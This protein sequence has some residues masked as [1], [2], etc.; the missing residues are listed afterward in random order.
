MIRQSEAGMLLCLCSKNNEADVF[1]VFD[2]RAEML[3]NREYVVFQDQ[4][5]S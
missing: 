3:L 5:E 4:L 1:E 2:Q